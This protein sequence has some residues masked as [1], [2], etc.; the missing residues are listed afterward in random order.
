[1]QEYPID[2]KAVIYIHYIYIHRQ[3]LKL[4]ELAGRHT[5]TLIIKWILLD[6]IVMMSADNTGNLF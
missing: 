4:P 1:M 3:Y 2:A 5:I 6:Q